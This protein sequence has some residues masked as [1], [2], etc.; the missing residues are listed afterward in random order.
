MGI[1][2]VTILSSE[3]SDHLADWNVRGLRIVSCDPPRGR[4]EVLGYDRGGPIQ[5]DYF[6]DVWLEGE[7]G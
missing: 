6:Y 2:K 3:L 4:G 7:E 5:E 1:R